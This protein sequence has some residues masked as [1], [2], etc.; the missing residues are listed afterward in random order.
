VQQCSRRLE[1]TVLLVLRGA[2]ANHIAV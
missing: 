1:I 2:R